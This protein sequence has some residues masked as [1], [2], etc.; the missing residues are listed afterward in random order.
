MASTVA[1]DVDQRDDMPTIQFTNVE[2]LFQVARQTQGD[3]LIVKVPLSVFEDLSLR[4]KRPFRIRRYHVN[5]RLLIITTRTYL[6]EK[7]HLELWRILDLQFARN[8]QEDDWGPIGSTTFRTPGHPGGD[9]GEAD[10]SGGP[11][12]LRGLGGSWPTLVIDAGDSESI[13]ALQDDMRWWFSASNHDV[14]IVLLAK[15][16]RRHQKSL[17]RDGKRSDRTAKELQTHDRRVVILSD[18]YYGRVSVSHGT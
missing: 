4:E 5:Q 12:P 9:G 8:N 13:L 7:L 10:S 11:W 16:D 18:R 3:F 14:K 17:S 6:H 2:D 1:S 15:F